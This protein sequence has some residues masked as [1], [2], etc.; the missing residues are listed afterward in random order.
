LSV[1]TKRAA[2][3]IA[4]LL[5]VTIWGV[6]RRVGLIDSGHSSP[7]MVG[8]VAVDAFHRLVVLAATSV[9][10]WLISHGLHTRPF[11]KAPK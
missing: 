8:F 2:F 6:G 4:I 1:R 3:I 5:A 11:V 9:S 7:M 10:V